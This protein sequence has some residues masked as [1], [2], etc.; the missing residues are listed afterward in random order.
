MAISFNAVVQR[1]D[2]IF[3]EDTVDVDEVKELLESYKSKKDDWKKYAIF[4]THRYTRNLV[5]EGNGKYNLM[6][7]CWGPGMGSSI[8]DH[9]DA[10]CFVKMLQGELLET[11]YEWPDQGVDKPMTPRSK[12]TYD[13]NGV[14][15]IN[16][17]IGLHRMENPSHTEYTVSMHLYIPPFR[18]CLAFEERTGHKNRVQVTFWSKFG[19]RTPIRDQMAAAEPKNKQQQQLI[20]NGFGNNRVQA[21]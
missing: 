1:L 13:T 10:H 21:N 18:S 15:Y 16:D 19:Q 20:S 9:A 3:S 11:Q 8:H 17:S 4:D 2:E 5:A 12:T 7:L 6:L 14:A